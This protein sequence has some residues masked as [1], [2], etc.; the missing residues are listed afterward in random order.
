MITVW[1]IMTPKNEYE[2]KA[3]EQQVQLLT[4]ALSVAAT[5]SGYW[6]NMSGRYYPRF[7]PKGP[8]ISPF[9]ALTLGLFADRN[10]YK[11][12]LYTFYPEAKMRNEP[13]KEGEK[14]VP[15]NWYNWKEYVH[16]HNP[17]D[18]ITREAYMLLEPEDKKQYKGIHNR[19][20]RKLF[21]IDQTMTPYVDPEEYNK[22]MERY[23]TLQERG[24]E[25]ANE[26]Q[27]RTMVNG[28]VKAMK[29]NMVP[30]RRD[31]TAMAHYDVG[32]DVIYVPDIKNYPHYIDY[33]QDLM[34][35][36]ARATGHQQRCA[37]EGMVMKGG[38]APSEE[39]L[40]REELV[41]ELVAGIKM[42][43]LGLPARLLPNSLHLV[44]EWNRELREDP[45]MI[46][47]VEADINNA[48]DI[49]R[50]AEKGEKVTYFSEMNEQVTEEMKEKKK[51]SVSSEESAILTDIIRNRGMLI[52]DGNFNSEE[53]KKKFLE[54]FDMAYHYE[55]FNHAMALT[56]D[57]DPE[58]AEVA[59][60]EALRCSSY[61]DEL[62][63]GYKPSEWIDTGVY[64]IYDALKE[65]PDR[66]THDFVVITA[67]KAGRADVI[68][69]EGAFAGGKV[70]LPDGKT[71]NFLL[72]PDEVMSA[73]ERS[74]KGARVQNNDL[75]GMSKQRITHALEGQGAKYVRFFNT[76][77]IA[78]FRPNDA[79][80]DGKRVGIAKL[81]QW[82]LT[83]VRE[84]NVSEAVEKSRS[85][86]FDRVQMIRDDANRWV[87]YMAPMGETPFCMHP[88]KSDINQFFSTSKQG[89]SEDTERIRR[90]LGQKY[91]AMSRVNPDLKID[92][93]GEKA[94]VEDIA[95]VVRANVYKTKEGKFLIS[96]VFEG[97]EKV[98]P[99]A[100]TNS[101]WQRLW[102]SGDINA[103]KNNMAALLYAD[104]LHPQQAQEQNTEHKHEQEA[105]QSGGMRR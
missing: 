97:M 22:M 6:M 104:L 13:V 15:F 26:R 78:S 65:M 76:G 81:N 91:Y 61:I 58:V 17:G 31:G 28:F 92:M 105:V 3:A 87:L 57:E 33:V 49:I 99:R 44:D 89:N 43:E 51:P 5:G 98:E 21:N 80:F 74:V 40:K 27:L 63:R 38:V 88:D 66:V 102:L 45:Q 56:K 52:A 24:N 53:D 77:G 59:F 35:E 18:T 67:P 103:Y 25:R 12:G 2:A 64:T 41:V 69:P 10:G 94:S 82:E 100:M 54:K 83:D 71:H 90:E 86:N 68:M 73:E 29:D 36:I 75:K 85:V 93:F 96:P 7:Y 37:R 9:N 34:R 20:I 19:E 70:V 101:Q 1:R 30:I 11:T 95:R 39:A 23:G 8:E 55:Q 16:R 46:D 48:M 72:S 79:Y 4:E 47:T 62:A 60:T 14:G 84:M 50:K 32:K 42:L